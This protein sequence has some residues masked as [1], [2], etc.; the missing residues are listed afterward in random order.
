M[1]TLDVGV[2]RETLKADEE[3]GDAVAVGE[4]PLPRMTDP[5]WVGASPV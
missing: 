2:G 5:T 1:E 3:V 4:F